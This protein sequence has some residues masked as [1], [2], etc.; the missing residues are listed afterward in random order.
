MKLIKFVPVLLLAIFFAASPLIMAV[1]ASA[2]DTELYSYNGTV[3]PALPANLVLTVDCFVI[4]E[5]EHGYI[6]FADNYDNADPVMFMTPDGSINVSNSFSLYLLTYD[7]RWV[8]Y[9]DSMASGVQ[10]TLLW[11]THDFYVGSEVFLAGSEPVP[12]VPPVDPDVDPDIGLDPLPSGDGVYYKAY[13]L[14]L[15]HIYGVDSSELTSDQALTLTGVS[16]IAAL[17]LVSLPFLLVFALIKL[18][19]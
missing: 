7:G 10:G 2:A 18:F 4:F 11:S 13:D 1:P 6:L 15:R 9:P 14:F 8:S 19:R 17:F 12:Y 3:L 16:T 5:N